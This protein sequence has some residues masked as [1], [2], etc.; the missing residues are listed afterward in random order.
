VVALVLVVASAANTAPA[1]AKAN[2]ETVKEDFLNVEY[3]M[4]NTPMR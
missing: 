3:D 2:T 1:N 4:A